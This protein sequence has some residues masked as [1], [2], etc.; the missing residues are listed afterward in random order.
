MS[1]PEDEEKFLGE[2]PIG[3]DGPCLGSNMTLTFIENEDMPAIPNAAIR[4]TWRHD[5]KVT[6]PVG[7]DDIAIPDE[8]IV[9]T[10]SD[11]HEGDTDMKLAQEEPSD[12]IAFKENQNTFESTRKSDARQKG[13]TPAR[14]HGGIKL[15]RKKHSPVAAVLATG[16]PEKSQKGSQNR[17]ARTPERSC[18]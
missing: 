3:I 16:A 6:S 14:N 15:P 18:T 8:I 1:L 17:D 4:K 9:D 11:D 5:F 10:G 2:G 12:T 13:R 7:E